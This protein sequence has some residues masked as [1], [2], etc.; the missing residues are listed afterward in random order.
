MKTSV[1]TFEDP[2]VTASERECLNVFSLEEKSDLEVIRA[3]IGEIP[4]NERI[5]DFG[6][7][8]KVH[9]S[10]PGTYDA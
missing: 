4:C 3:C 8:A 5:L 7:L 6:D 1:L 9:V 2:E 10:F